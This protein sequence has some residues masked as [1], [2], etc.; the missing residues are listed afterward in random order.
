MER[1]IQIRRNW[2][3]I[4]I[5]FFEIT[6]PIGDRK[7]LVKKNSTIVPCKVGLSLLGY[8]YKLGLSCIDQ[9]FEAGLI[10]NQGVI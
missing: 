10:N 9:D 5:G 7:N 4:I 2:L 8:K 1:K 3:E 6:L